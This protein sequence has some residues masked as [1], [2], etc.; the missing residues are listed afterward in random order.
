MMN[1][2]RPARSKNGCSSCRR[3][4]VRCDESKPVCNACTRLGLT[5]SYEP[6]RASSSADTPRY[7][8]RFV[9]SRYTKLPPDE[10][11]DA[12]QPQTASPRIL[13]HH[14]DSEP[15]HSVRETSKDNAEPRSSSNESVMSHSSPI[16]AS[17]ITQP[18]PVTSPKAIPDH[19]PFTPSAQL[20]AYETRIDTGYVPAFFDLNMN[21]DLLG[22]DWL[23]PQTP[24]DASIQ[25]SESL[26]S[27]VPEPSSST[28]DAT[29]V[30][31]PDDHR[32][33]QHYFNVMTSYA[34]I[35]SSGDDNIYSHIFSNMALFYAPLYS[36]LM[37]WTALHLGQTNSE[38]GLIQRAE[39]LYNQAVSLTYQDQNVAIHFELSIV[40]IWFAL[41][42]ELL[43]ARG[44][45]HFC[46]HLEF[47]ADLVY[48]HRRHQKAGGEATPLGHIGSRMLVWLGAYDARAS[49]IG[50]SG[51]LLQNLES[52]CA[53]YDFIDA[54]FP[55]LPGNTE[56]LKPCLRLSLELDYMES[57]IVQLHRRSVTV[58]SLS[59]SNVQSGLITIRDRLESDPS[60]A[61]I[62]NFITNPTRTL[63]GRITTRRFNCLLLLATF[64]G[65]VISFHR[66]LPTSMATNMPGKLV[67]AEEA[68]AYIIRL[69]SWVGRFRPPSPQNIWPR[70][71]FMA[72][73]ETTDI[74]YQDWAIKNLA[75]AEVW[76]ANFRKTRLL[77][78][79]IIKI[80]SSEGVRVDYLDVMK[81][82]TGL[83]II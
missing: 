57:R 61:P 74:A 62:I 47:V 14:V 81:Q 21:F 34:K 26:Q 27:E 73:I 8:V 10:P 38:P 29:V 13:K 77:L 80:Q 64:Y 42:Y 78:E 20:N 7:R 82:D 76:G 19:S 71:L 32:L 5:C 39:E 6:N 56:D 68:A 24:G 37:A 17:A 43:A 72:G 36:A 16:Q 66:M 54:A 46:Q 12:Y 55:N 52:F 31:G 23:S 65:V 22:G 53:E 48:A 9:N 4:K 70:I 69:A 40:T 49:C 41:Q 51:R 30:V 1:R 60:V 15:A 63:T 75:E 50:G 83:F 33:I 67:P 2:T 44:I 79:R 59:W 28:A 11:K 35:R 58:P 25:E 3:R 45:N 18:Q